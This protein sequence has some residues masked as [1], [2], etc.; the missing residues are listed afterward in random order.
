MT[1]Y[2][3]FCFKAALFCAVIVKNGLKGLTYLERAIVFSPCPQVPMTRKSTMTRSIRLLAKEN[4]NSNNNNN[5]K[6][7]LL[8]A[9]ISKYCTYKCK[10]SWL[11]QKLPLFKSICELQSVFI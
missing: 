6:L 4:N 9:S 8:K 2:R 1:H 3:K 10:Y 11:V 7:L 5:N